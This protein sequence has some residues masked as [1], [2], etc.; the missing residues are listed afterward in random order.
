MPSSQGEALLLHILMS[1]RQILQDNNSSIQS[2]ILGRLLSDLVSGAAELSFHSQ[3]ISQLEV[4]RCRA[5]FLEITK[6]TPTPI[7]LP[8]LTSFLQPTSAP[9]LKDP[10]SSVLSKIPL[11]KEGVFQTITFLASQFSPEA[12]TTPESTGPPITAQAIMQSSRILSSI[13]R[14]VSPEYFLTNVGPKL[15]SLLDGDDMDLRKTASYII[16]NGILPKRPIGAPGTIGFTIFIKPIFDAFHGIIGESSTRWL[17]RFNRDGSPVN[18]VEASGNP[19]SPTLADTHQLSLSLARLTSLIV[20]HPNPALVKRLIGPVMLPLWG[21]HWCAESKNNKECAEQTFTLLQ[22]FF[23]ISSGKS[24]FERLIR[25]IMWDGGE[26]WTYKHDI[27]RGIFVAKREH[28]TPERFDI[29]QMVGNIDERVDL[30]LNFMGID[31]QRETY[32]G[33][34]FLFVSRNWLTGDRECSDNQTPVT[35]SDDTLPGLHKVIFAKIAEKLISQHQDILCRRL[36]QILELVNQLIDSEMQLNKGRNNKIDTTNPT[37]Q[38]IGNIVES[39]KKGSDPADTAESPE[40]LSAALSLLSTLLISS[41]LQIG[42]DMRPVLGVTKVK[43]DELLPFISPTLKQPATTVSTLIEFVVAGVL[44]PDI[45]KPRDIPRLRHVS[46]IEAHR[47]A[48]DS[49]NSPLPPVQVE[50]LS[51][52]SRLIKKA[53]PVLDIPATLTL[54]LSVIMEDSS[55]SNDEFVYLNVI[56][57]IG[58][59]ASRHP[60]T[61]IRTLAER[62]KDNNEDATLDQRLRIGE[63]LLRTVQELGDALVGD[64]AQFLGDTMIAVAGRRGIKPKANERRIGGTEGQD[65]ENDQTKRNIEGLGQDA[66]DL[67]NQ[68][69]QHTETEPEDPVKTAHSNKILQAWAS[70]AASDENPDDLRIRTSAMS[71]L[72]VAIQTNS[73]GLGQQVISASVDM[74]LST[75]NLEPGPENAIIRRAA[76][77][78][79]LDIIKSLDKAM[80][81]GSDPGFTFSQ[82][83]SA[84]GP[85]VD[86]TKTTIGNI[87]DILRVLNFIE[88]KE[89]DMIV[90]GHIRILIESLEAWTEKSILRGIGAGAQPQ[91]ELGDRLAGLDI[92]PLSNTSGIRR[93]PQIEEIE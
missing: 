39:S 66:A 34:I 79:L 47:H 12:P 86:I 76:I 42:D 46:D 73:S 84:Y 26:T 7:L 24:R 51:L 25:N 28:S 40:P 65:L 90:R 70:G 91:L 62:Y 20:L 88:S 52:L 32:I 53:S 81:L 37:L 22:N 29:I 61:A 87:P 45:R 82:S 27:S 63:A 80:E 17:R 50:G 55:N 83:T 13:P 21:L 36:D 56:K 15:L 43:I 4:E 93:R 3:S 75:L 31:P 71:I 10:I 44:A 16:G 54:L 33:E 78:L 49:L 89:T 48:L 2:I 14:G 64:T 30:L 41:D 38:S 8:V 68:M 18:T 11:R 19:N 1:L 35:F 69:G 59:L 6:D 57:L 74:A 67:I 23:S 92:N 58:I 60:S 85:R 72:A 77:V 5:M 9:W